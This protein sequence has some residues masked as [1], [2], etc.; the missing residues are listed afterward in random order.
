VVKAQ[1]ANANDGKLGIELIKDLVPKRPLRAFYAD[2]GYTGDF[3]YRVFGR[4]GI[5]PTIPKPLSRLKDRSMSNLK[6]VRW[7]VER[8]LA[9]F[10]HYRR[11][12]KDYE[13]TPRASEAMVYIAMTQ[14]LLRRLFRLLR[15]L[16]KHLP[17]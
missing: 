1:R 5:W 11:L 8:T 6:P 12:S 7:V 16:L 13:K 14:L 4:F 15:E 2:A 9:W 3:E 10:N 17:Q